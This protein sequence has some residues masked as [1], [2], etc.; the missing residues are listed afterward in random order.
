MILAQRGSFPHLRS[1]DVGKRRIGILAKYRHAATQLILAISLVFCGGL[2]KAALIEIAPVYSGNNNASIGNDSLKFL[3]DDRKTSPLVGFSGQG[4]RPVAGSGHDKFSRNGSSAMQ[5]G[6]T[7]MLLHA[8]DNSGA[9]DPDIYA[10]IDTP[11][12]ATLDSTSSPSNDSDPELW[13]V[14]LVAA[15]L[16]GY[17]LKRKSRV[18]A[19]RVRPLHF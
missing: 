16:I 12:G 11:Y 2:A 7:G 18:G 9:K 13:S 19:I 6:E 17:Q 4:I 5:V 10:D 14:L 8:S 15:G 3:Y 1:A